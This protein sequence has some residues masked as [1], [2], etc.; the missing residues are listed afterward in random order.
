L[1]DPAIPYES[2]EAAALFP[3][4]LRG[5][6]YLAGGDGQRAQAEFAKVIS[7]RG[8]V[9][10]SP[11]GVLAHLQLAH[12]YQIQG[13]HDQAKAAYQ[14]FLFRWKDADASLPVLQTAQSESAR[15]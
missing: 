13:Q 9:L 5:L 15:I 1:L 3:A 14:D 2:G 8:I 10:A 12:A 4:Y 6:A 7:G 11:I